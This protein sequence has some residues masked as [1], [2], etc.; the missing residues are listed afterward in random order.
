MTAVAEQVVVAAEDGF[1]IDGS[2]QECIGR[3]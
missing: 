3:R 1:Q 2:A